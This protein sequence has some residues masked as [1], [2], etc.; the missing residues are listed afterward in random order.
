MGGEAQ[1]L[2]FRREAL[3]PAQRRAQDADSALSD[4]A[5]APAGQKLL[6]SLPAEQQ[7]EALSSLLA[8][9]GKE[10]RTSLLLGQLAPS[11]MSCCRSSQS[12]PAC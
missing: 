11:L 12:S 10:E 9:L 3:A 1:R 4:R 7:A 2:N 8:S 6:P 5:G